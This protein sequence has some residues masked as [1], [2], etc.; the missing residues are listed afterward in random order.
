MGLAEKEDT[1]RVKDVLQDMIASTKKLDALMQSFC[2]RNAA[3]G[4]CPKATSHGFITYSSDD[5]TKRQERSAEIGTSTV[6]YLDRMTKELRGMVSHQCVKVPM[7]L[8]LNQPLTLD[9]DTWSLRGNDKI[10]YRV[11]DVTVLPFKA[12]ENQLVDAIATR[13]RT[14]DCT[15]DADAA[16]G[17]AQRLVYVT[18]DADAHLVHSG[19]LC[20]PSPP[21]MNVEWKTGTI[22][23][24]VTVDVGL[25]GTSSWGLGAA[26]ELEAILRCRVDNGSTGPS[27]RARYICAFHVDPSN[28]DDDDST[29]QP[30]RRYVVTEHCILLADTPPTAPHVPL[31]TAVARTTKDANTRAQPD[32]VDVVNILPA[33][34]TR[35]LAFPAPLG[36]TR[37]VSAACSPVHSLFLSDVGAV[38]A[39]GASLDGALGLGSQYEAP[40]PQLVEF[41]DWKIVVQVAAGGDSTGAH[42]M[43]VTSEGHVFTWGMRLACGTD[44]PPQCEH[45]EQVS[46]PASTIHCV[47]V[48]AGGSFSMALTDA[49]Q[50]Y[51]WGKYL[52]GRLGLG[53]PPKRTATT[54]GSRN[55]QLVERLPRLIPG[56]ASIAQIACGHAH[57]CCVTHIGQIFSWGKNSHGQLGTGH[58]V[59]QLSPAPVAF[60]LDNN[61]KVHVRTVAC[62]RDFTLALDHDGAVWT[63]GAGLTGLLPPAVSKAHDLPA[64]AW[65][66]P[67][68]VDALGSHIESIAAGPAHASVVTTA[69]DVFAWGHISSDGWTAMPQLLAPS[70][71]VASVACTEGA[72]WATVG[73]TFLGQSIFALYRERACCDLVLLVSGKR[74]HVHQMIVSYRCPV[75]RNVIAAQLRDTPTHEVILPSSLRHDVCLLVVEYLYTDMLYTPMMDPSSCLPRDLRRAAIELDLPGLVALCHRIM[76]RDDDDDDATNNPHD[77]TLGPCLRQA[78][79]SALFSDVTIIA[80][81]ESI[82]AHKCILVARSDYFR[83]LCTTSMRESASNTLHV[84]VSYATMQRVLA[85]LYSDVWTPPEDDD[86][87]LDDMVAADKYGIGRLKVLCEAHA[88]ITL[89]NCMEL[90]VMA[91]MIHAPL[92]HEKAITFILNQLHVLADAPSFLQL[93]QDYPKLLHEIIHHPSRNKERMLWRSWETQATM[94]KDDQ[95]TPLPS[96]PWVPFVFLI[97]FGISYLHVSA[98]LPQYG[99]YVPWFNAVF[100]FALVAYFFRNLLVV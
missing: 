25:H 89:E 31:A 72:T 64:W 71:V 35:P 42:S 100:M 66:R 10:V 56:L 53:K 33:T 95:A 50:V 75:L 46:F 7:D 88:M 91:D 84:D 43:A 63:W 44:G 76:R 59:D 67:Q 69:G 61:D 36:R 99:S 26:V 90:L 55:D 92:L 57:A 83:A 6:D 94:P 51:V 15:L 87:L 82:H 68:R 27:I 96:F 4:A 23:A 2:R 11:N 78:C 49:G 34:S 81:G 98:Q 77:D 24:Q 54:R 16:D 28:D 86:V 60:P 80:E 97:A 30:K 12:S 93:A 39:V 65:L 14:A 47:Q 21:S 41:I 17:M 9:D 13:I 70:R 22:I 37:I 58:L 1:L 3:L 29:S 79:G 19:R 20:F 18:Q 62:G 32:L 48:A 40:C 38:F 73:G 5:L 45:P 8:L 74:I 85:Y 52:N